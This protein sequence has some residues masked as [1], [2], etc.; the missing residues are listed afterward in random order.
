MNFLRNRLTVPIKGYNRSLIYDLTRNDY[1]FIPN[2]LFEIIATETNFE[3][4]NDEYKKIL[5]D[6]EIIFEI[7]IDD[8]QLF[9][10]LELKFEDPYDF[11]NLLIDSDLSVS[12]YE[13]FKDAL[14]FNLTILVNPSY[15][16]LKISTSL[17]DFIEHTR[18]ESIDIHFLKD[19]FELNNI[20]LDT[21]RKNA[22]VFNIYLYNSRISSDLRMYLKNHYIDLIE[23][24]LSFE[25]YS[26]NVYPS[27]FSVNNDIFIEANSKNTYL[28]KKLYIDFKGDIKNSFNTEKLCNISDINTFFELIRNPMLTKYWDITKES[29]LICKDCEFRFMCVNPIKLKKTGENWIYDIECNYNPYISKW[30]EEDDYLSLKSVGVNINSLGKIEINHEMIEEINKTIWCNE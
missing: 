30:S 2:E 21:I 12:C 15:S 23:I 28:N 5:L 11:T 6:N 3:I 29:I 1:F 14:I 16:T 19:D 17:L 9:P 22:E 4:Y 7:D 8:V 27:K 10:S 24:P 25:A 13:Q 26:K 20:N 18:P